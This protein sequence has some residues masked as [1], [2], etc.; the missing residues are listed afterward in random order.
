MTEEPPDSFFNG[1]F[2]IVNIQW[3][4]IFFNITNNNIQT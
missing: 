4:V 3:A 1:T 2:K